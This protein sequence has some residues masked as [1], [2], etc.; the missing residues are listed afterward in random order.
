MGSIWIP[1]VHINTGTHILETG[2]A[3]YCDYTLGWIMYGSNPGRNKRFYVHQHIQT[4]S[5]S[6]PV[7]AAGYIMGVKW[8]V[9]V[10]A[11]L[12]LG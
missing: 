7:G 8:P 11:L 1:V 10:T 9:R 5:G 3:Y 6:H 2:L 12:H 4:S